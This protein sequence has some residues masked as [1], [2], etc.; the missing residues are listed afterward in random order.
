MLFRSNNVSAEDVTI[1]DIDISWTGGVALTELRLDNSKKWD[2]S[3][4]SPAS[5]DISD[6]VVQAGDD[7]ELELRFASSIEGSTITMT[8]YTLTGDEY[9][10]VFLAQE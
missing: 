9:V 3:E 2:G 7:R 10:F 4:L 6:T 5:L 8:A 1:T